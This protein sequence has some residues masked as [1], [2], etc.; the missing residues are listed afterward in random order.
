MLCTTEPKTD[1]NKGYILKFTN[2][3][4]RKVMCYL[5]KILCFW[6]VAVLIICAF[7][8][9]KTTKQLVKVSYIILFRLMYSTP[10][11]MFFFFYFIFN[12]CS[13]CYFSFSLLQN[14][15]K[16]HVVT[17]YLSTGTATWNEMPVQKQQTVN[18]SSTRQQ[19]EWWIWSFINFK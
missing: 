17:L 16:D 3:I 15:L 13:Q 10:Y 7:N 19:S 1:H 2:T 11:S 14:I 4:W 9:I 6:G 8:S 18:T 5:Y 12:K